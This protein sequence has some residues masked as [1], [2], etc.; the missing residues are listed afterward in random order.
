MPAASA[1][2]AGAST[3]CEHHNHCALTPGLLHPA[4]TH[5]WGC[6]MPKASTRRAA[7]KDKREGKSA[8]TQAG[9]YVK[10]EI[11]QVRMGA[12]GVKN[13]KQAIAIGLSKARRDG[14]DAA[15]SRSASKA[16]K[17]KAAQDTAAAKNGTPTSPTRSAG[18]KKAL[19]TAS[20]KTTA[21]TT[22]GKQALSA[23]GK[24]AAEK[25][26]SGNRSA[27]AKKAAK[28]K[29]PAVRKQAAKKAARTRKQT[30]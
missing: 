22:V 7:A 4:I 12:H 28:T 16:T 24:Q 3:F 18:A 19:K 6:L 26:T 30:G 9:E 5:A 11:D 29:G 25:R 1:G 10:E 13:T 17:N 27:A 8:S 15:P 23:Q 14:V 20:K 21:R 2:I